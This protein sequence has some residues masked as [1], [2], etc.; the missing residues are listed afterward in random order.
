MRVS[1]MDN[2][3]QRTLG[4]LACFG[5]A[6]SEVTML[7]AHAALSAPTGNAD[8][9]IWIGGWAAVMRRSEALT[10]EDTEEYWEDEQEA[11]SE[12]LQ[13]HGQQ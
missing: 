4:G 9:W 5:L 8:D 7:L 10:E 12:F 6:V 13:V 1:A 3:S 2:E 11:V